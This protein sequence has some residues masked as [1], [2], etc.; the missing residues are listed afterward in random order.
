MDIHIKAMEVMFDHV[1]LFINVSPN[2]NIIKVINGLKGLSS[3]LIRKKYKFLNIYK[4]LWTPS[5]FLE[6]IGYISENT[7][8]KYIENQK[9]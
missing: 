3:Y 5:Y 1:H 8:I 9:K 7:V 4:A 6:S 2:I